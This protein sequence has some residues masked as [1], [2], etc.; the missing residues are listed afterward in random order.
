MRS[1]APIY[2]ASE[3]HFLNTDTWDTLR[4]ATCSGLGLAPMLS[5]Q[6]VLIYPRVQQ[7]VD[8]AFISFR[9][10]SFLSKGIP[11][12]TLGPLLPILCPFVSNQHIYHVHLGLLPAVLWLDLSYPWSFRPLLVRASCALQLH[13]NIR[14]IDIVSSPTP[15]TTSR[16]YADTINQP[17]LPQSC[18]PTFI[19]ENHQ[20]PQWLI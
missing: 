16:T 4:P 20:F 18:P 3:L 13:P 8:L 7:F 6:Y 12:T 17:N 15:L 2:L 14:E 9:T 1:Y 11:I 10:S 19:N 5:S